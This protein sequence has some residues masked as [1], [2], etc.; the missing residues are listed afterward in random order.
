MW[1]AGRVK[2]P[3]AAYLWRIPH[4]TQVPNACPT[5]DRLPRLA[6]PWLDRAG[7]LSR[8]KLA[9]FLLALAPGLWFTGAYALDRLGAKPLTAYLHAMGDWSVRF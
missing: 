3:L 6:Y 1:S 9:V 8:F 5:P 4:R 2:P 7:R